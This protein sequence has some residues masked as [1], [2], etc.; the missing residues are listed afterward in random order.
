[1][2]PMWLRQGKSL[3]SQGSGLIQGAKLFALCSPTV[4]SSSAVV[5]LTMNGTW[6]CT[7]VRPPCLSYTFEKG[8]F[9]L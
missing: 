1:M 7:T 5:V 2:Q 3:D 9:Y 4:Q 6:S 8:F